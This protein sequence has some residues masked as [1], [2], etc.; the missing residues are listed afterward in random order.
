MNFLVKL[1]NKLALFLLIFLAILLISGAI[2]SLFELKVFRQKIGELIGYFIAGGFL[3]LLAVLIINIMGNLTLI[4]QNQILRTQHELGILNTQLSPEQLNLLGLNGTSKKR[5][6]TTLSLLF[7]CIT[8]IIVFLFWGDYNSSQIKENNFKNSAEAI[9]SEDPML[10]NLLS[11]YTFQKEYLARLGN[12]LQIISNQFELVSN[13]KMI[14]LDQI[15]DEIVL[16]GFDKDNLDN[17]GDIS[18]EL[19]K[20]NFLFNTSKNEREYLLDTLK[21]HKDKP[22]FL[23][24]KNSYYYYV[25]I[26]TNNGTIVIRFSDYLRYGKFGS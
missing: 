17:A 9:I 13:I 5:V 23:K 7:C 21:N 15:D 1:S 22:L 24:E 18:N 3:A 11:Q 20:I 26:Q 19:N 14:V 2:S 10:N 4:A 25:P 8:S 16:L 12:K 6:I